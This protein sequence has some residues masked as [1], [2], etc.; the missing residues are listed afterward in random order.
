MNLFKNGF[1]Y[2]ISLHV[3]LVLLMYFTNLSFTKNI[4][5]PIEYIEI[6]S[7]ENIEQ[8]FQENNKSITSEPDIG[9][10]TPQIQQ[11]E[12]NPV[13]VP[14]VTNV[15]EPIAN[16]NQLPED[17][18]KDI[19]TPSQTNMNN[20][21]L[22]ADLGNQLLN[23]E[24]D[25]K[26]NS[27]N[28]ENLKIDGFDDLIKENFEN[29]NISGEV[30]NRRIINKFLPKFPDNVKENGTVL[31]EF[32]VNQAGYVQNIRFVSG[33]TEFAVV[34]IEAFKEWVFESA[35]KLQTGSITFRFIIE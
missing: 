7:I 10:V 31:L 23:D 11:P 34:A 3:L 18:I 25:N 29:F 30:A 2:S 19:Y 20:N 1:F 27:Y 14:K 13:E 33:K 12:T 24:N 16:L 15:F 28:N 6:I 35:S 32:D 17:P 4:S 9:E 26:N 5:L 21:Y 22:S 8:V